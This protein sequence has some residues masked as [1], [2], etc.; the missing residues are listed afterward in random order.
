MRKE[1]AKKRNV[2]SK[3]GVSEGGR[4]HIYSLFLILP[5]GCIFSCIRIS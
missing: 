4:S 1:E 5:V 2:L 3:G